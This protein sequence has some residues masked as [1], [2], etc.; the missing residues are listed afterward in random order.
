M[1]IDDAGNSFIYK[2]PAIHLGFD[3]RDAWIDKYN[4]LN[5]MLG[6]AG[7]P[8]GYITWDTGRV[9]T[10]RWA[11][12]DH[13]H[14]AVGRIVDM[15]EILSRK[16]MF[17]R[18]YE[19]EELWENFKY[20]L[21]RTLPVCKEANIKLALHPNDPPA[22]QYEGCASLIYNV[23]GYKKALA[24]ADNSPYLGLKFCCG[25]WLEGGA[26]FG[27][28][29]E[30]L[31]YFIAQ[32]RVYTIHFRNVS[33]VLPYFE[34]TL[35]EDGYMDMYQIMRL[36]VQEKYTGPLHVDHVLRYDEATGGNM[37]SLAYTTGYMKG[38]MN[39]AYSELGR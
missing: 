20:F 25:C 5:R 30:D 3:D 19:E 22:P 35:L 7:V 31:R 34:E 32:D 2:H 38:L 15:E 29:L 6:N 17:G 23:D 10:S 24:M 9:S 36:L 13:T 16:P 33:G 21:D 26:A 37:A 4:D 8:V 11:V 39:A 28:V 18:V 27:N 12:G 14:G 1:T